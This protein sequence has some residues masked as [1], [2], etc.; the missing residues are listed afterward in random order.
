MIRRRRLAVLDRLQR[1]LQP[2]HRPCADHASGRESE[3][4]FFN[5]FRPRI[6]DTAQQR[7]ALDV[8]RSYL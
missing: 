8:I 7:V 2:D 3:S 1:V 4:L 6:T 5:S